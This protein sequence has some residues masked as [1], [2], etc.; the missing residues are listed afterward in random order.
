MPGLLFEADAVHRF[1]SRACPARGS[2]QRQTFMPTLRSSSRLT[3]AVAL[4]ITALVTVG[5]WV[6]LLFVS[7]PNLV[8]A[9]YAFSSK[10]EYRWFFVIFTV[11][12]VLSLFLGIVVAI[13]R[14]RAVLQLALVAC[15]V[16]AVLLLLSGAFLLAPFAAAPLWW[17][18]K[19]Q[20]EV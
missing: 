15:V 14:R 18:Y 17:L 13:T 3:V 1:R 2:A 9:R 19:A 8:F 16:Q 6:V 10:N 4:L 11:S 5:I 7:N 20:H 12:G